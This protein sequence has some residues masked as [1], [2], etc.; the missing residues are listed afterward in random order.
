MAKIPSVNKETDVA[1]K[2]TMVGGAAVLDAVV[3]VVAGVGCAVVV[4]VAETAA[5]GQMQQQK[6]QR[7]RNSKR[8]CNDMP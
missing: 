3:V 7:G 8:S 1:L 5:K 2:A 6:G 4:V